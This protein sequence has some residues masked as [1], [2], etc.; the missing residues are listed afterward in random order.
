MS[1][2][3]INLIVVLV[4]IG[5]THGKP[6]IYSYE[7][8]TLPEDCKKNYC[9][10]RSQYYPTE[11]IDDM[12]V[13]LDYNMN[14]DD[15]FITKRISD[16]ADSE[17][18]CEKNSY[19][20]PVYQIIDENDQVRYVIQSKKFKQ[21]VRI[22]ECLYPGRITSDS[23]HFTETELKFIHL[24]CAETYLDYAFL[25]LSLNGTKMESVRAKGGIPVYCACKL[26]SL[27]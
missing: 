14:E 8:A 20:Q 22:E 27:Y 2:K 7:N 24:A 6:T 3:I 21:V 1:Y 11:L 23:K 5:A 17:N 15:D 18:D 4:I 10:S 13:E 26:M 19:Y 9:F 16:N 12:L 25:V